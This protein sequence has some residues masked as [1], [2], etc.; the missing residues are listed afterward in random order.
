MSF[1]IP[2]GKFERIAFSLSRLKLLR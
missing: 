2:K 1:V